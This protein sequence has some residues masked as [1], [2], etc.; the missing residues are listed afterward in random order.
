VTFATGFP[1]LTSGGPAARN[2]LEG[3]PRQVLAVLDSLSGRT[4]TP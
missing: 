1:V 4:G 2:L 3:Q